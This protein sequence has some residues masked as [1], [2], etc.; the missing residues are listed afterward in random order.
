MK[1]IRL[2][3]LPAACVAA[4]FQILMAQTAL[5]QEYR[6]AEEVKGIE[7]GGKVG[8]LNGVLADGTAYRLQN[9]L[10][11]GKTVVIFY[12]G[13][14]CPVCSR[15]LSNLQDSLQV[16]QDEGINVVAVSPEKPEKLAK[17]Q[18]K[19]KATF[20]LV[21]DRDYAFAKAFDVLFRPDQKTLGVYNT[22]LGADLKHSH[23]DES[24]QLPVPATF[25]LDENGVVLW[26]HVDPNYKNRASVASIIAAS[27]NN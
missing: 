5:A 9:D 16:L 14:W 6:T 2:K 18:Q 15:H 3:T 10:K 12:R 4:A 1:M 23:S 11:K 26:R 21:H 7:V 13:Q 19:T 22:M 20:T 17:T 25:L 24:Q 27:I 8:D